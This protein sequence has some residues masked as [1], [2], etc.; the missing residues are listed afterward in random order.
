MTKDADP[1]SSSGAANLPA[2]L[3]NAEFGSIKGKVI[4]VTG[5]NSKT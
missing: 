1:I 2:R 5:T 3:D 4:V